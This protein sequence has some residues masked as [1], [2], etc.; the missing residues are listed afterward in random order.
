MARTRSEEIPFPMT[1]KVAKLPRAGS[2]VCTSGPSVLP[3]EDLLINFNDYNS[4]T[5]A[6]LN[7]NSTGLH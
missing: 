3:S 6:K 2:L 7:H 1:E 4:M 5:L